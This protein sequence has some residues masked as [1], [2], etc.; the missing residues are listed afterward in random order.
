M[1]L[2]PLAAAS[3]GVTPSWPWQRR[4]G[5]YLVYAEAGDTVSFR[6]EFA[7]VG[8]YAGTEM[9]VTI[10]GPDGATVHEAK[11]PFQGEATISFTAP[12]TG[13]YTVVA[14]G[15]GNKMR[16]SDWSHPH[17]AHRRRRRGALHAIPGELQFTCPPVPRSSV[18]VSGARA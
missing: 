3:T 8:N 13:V 6:A 10:T 15:G 11:V 5:R 12:E 2:E 9:P 4:V 14:D 1:A 7:Q 18:C 17:G 16:L